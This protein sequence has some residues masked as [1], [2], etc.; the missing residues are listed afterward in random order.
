MKAKIIGYIVAETK[1]HN[2]GT[3]IYLET[4]HDEYKEENAKKIAGNACDTEY[5]RGDYSGVLKV[6]QTVELVYGKG[7]ES[8]AILREI[9]PVNEK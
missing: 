6:G 1:S 4:K 7:Y 2:I 8:K 9:V 3:T 5:I